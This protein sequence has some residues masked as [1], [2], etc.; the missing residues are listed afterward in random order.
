MNRLNNWFIKISHLDKNII[1]PD[2]I[3]SPL[4]DSGA[5]DGSGYGYGYNANDARGYGHYYSNTFKGL[6]YGCGK[7]DDRGFA[8][9]S[10]Y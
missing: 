9:G 7:A 6:E 4:C 10:S 2:D 8:D 1:Y 3:Y 5:P